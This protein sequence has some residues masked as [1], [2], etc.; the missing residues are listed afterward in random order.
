[1]LLLSCT[2]SVLLLLH[3]LAQVDVLQQELKRL[4]QQLAR[5][6]RAADTAL[7]AAKAEAL[8]SRESLAGAV[9]LGVWWCCW[10]LRGVFFDGWLYVAIAAAWSMVCSRCHPML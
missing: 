3:N 6:Q 8:S 10:Q 7:A 4:Q 5:Q 1:L 2:I 9:L